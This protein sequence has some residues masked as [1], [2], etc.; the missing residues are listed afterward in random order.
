MATNR[1]EVLCWLVQARA[2]SP[3]ALGQLL[4]AC[5]TYLLLIARQELDADLRAKGS[6]S[7]LVQETFLEAQR[8]FD[9]FRGE[10]EAELVAWLRQLLLHN[11]RDFTKRFARTGKR[12]L[13]REVSL[14]EVRGNGEL[15][16]LFSSDSAS[17]R[18][19][20]VQQERAERVRRALDRLPADYRHVLLLRYTEERSFEEIGERM[21]RSANAARKLWLRALERM[22]LELETPP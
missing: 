16:L 7:D 5:R 4:Q 13:V 22:E 17:P 9:Q 14:E 19:K 11:L 10:T 2:G 12:E 21:Q 15:G 1:A 6:A 8:D 3:E 20:L 18:E